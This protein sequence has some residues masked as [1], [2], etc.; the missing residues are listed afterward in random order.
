MEEHINIYLDNSALHSLSILREFLAL[1]L[2]SDQ[3]SHS[4]I[5]SSVVLWERS[6][7]Y[8][9]TKQ[10]E[11]R[12]SIVQYK[13]EIP[14]RQIISHFSSLFNAYNVRIAQMEERHHVVVSEI[15]SDP[16]SY[17]STDNEHDIRDAAILAI[18]LDNLDPNKTVVLC[19][20]SKLATEFAKR[21]FT[22]ERDA[23]KYVA[24]VLER[25]ES[26]SDIPIIS[27]V[28][29]SDGINGSGDIVRDVVNLPLQRLL[30]RADPIYFSTFEAESPSHSIVGNHL[31]AKLKE[32]NAKDNDL[33]TKLMGYTNW[34]APTPKGEL[35]SLLEPQGF[36]TE[37]IVVNTQFLCQEGL[38]IDTGTHLIPNYSDPE[39][40][41]VSEDAKNAVI[42]DMIE[43]L[44]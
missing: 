32:M 19:A 7:G 11:N 14:L 16:S 41:L 18:A 33:R 42:S 13:N 3:A 34:L 6:R 15:L 2:V 26:I 28:A 38:L 20:D 21:G 10:K 39:A 12:N 24:G 25:A 27:S 43:L 8:F 35:A 1:G 29:P 31:P 36:G 5:I 30:E 23:K 37:A 40:A 4:V 17:F 44:R 9:E 22:V